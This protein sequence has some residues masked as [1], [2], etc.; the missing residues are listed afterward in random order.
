MQSVSKIKKACFF[1][2]IAI[3]FKKLRFALAWGLFPTQ[4]I[5]LKIRIITDT[6]LYQ[7]SFFKVLKVFI[8]FFFNVLHSKKVLFTHIDTKDPPPSDFLPCGGFGS[9]FNALW[10]FFDLRHFFWLVVYLVVFGSKV[11]ILPLSV[12]LERVFEALYFHS[13][14]KNGI[15]CIELYIFRHF[16]RCNF[17]YKHLYFNVLHSICNKKTTAPPY[18]VFSLKNGIFFT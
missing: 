15:F 11:G 5:T 8:L 6:Y 12:C 16:Y 3:P 9:R 1:Q 7:Y 14:Q 18:I 2:N 4:R 13:V 17:I 10:F